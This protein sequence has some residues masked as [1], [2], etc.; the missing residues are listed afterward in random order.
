MGETCL[1]RR[2]TVLHVLR[3]LPTGFAAPV[4]V[5]LPHERGLTLGQIGASFALY[6][7]VVIALELPTG[8]WADRWGARPVLCAS[9]SAHTLGLAGVLAAHDMAILLPAAA[10]LGIGRA[11]GSGPLEAW[12]VTRL[13]AAGGAAEVPV[14][15]GRAST[16][17]GGALAMGALTVVLIPTR[18]FASSDPLALPVALAVVAGVLH[19]A[20]VAV[21]L[22][23][24]EDVTGDR[25]LRA[26]PVRRVAA[27][28]RASSE[29]R[30]VLVV[31]ALNAVGLVAVEMLW[32]PRFQQLFTVDDTVLVRLFGSFTAA[33]YAATAAGAWLSRRTLQWTRSSARTSTFAQ[34]LQAAALVALALTGHP[35][36]A[37]AAFLVTHFALGLFHPAVQQQL[38][39]FA[40]DEHRTTTVS[41]G[42]LALQLGAVT[43]QLTLTNL[44]GATTIPIAWLAASASV[45]LAA[46]IQ[47]GKAAEQATVPHLQP[48]SGGGP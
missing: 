40:R 22:R 27:Q 4:L 30:R 15:L 21:L 3:W 47:M 13:R 29:L 42:S 45:L 38:H 31:V 36:L 33:A 18:A 1:L 6:N 10:M 39:G 44:A 37:G 11:L 41:A 12:V 5:L 14:A 16:I 24:G 9:A 25:R 34:T 7:V 2:F 26:T 20:A 8:G 19:L 43:S 46:V 17:E 23:D 48:T 35:A 28:V 32:Q